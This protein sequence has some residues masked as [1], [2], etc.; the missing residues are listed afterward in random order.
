MKTV[1]DKLNKFGKYVCITAMQSGQMILSA[2]HTSVS[3]K[4]Y[5]N[6]LR[7]RYIG[8]MDPI[9]DVN[10]QVISK[11]NLKK[12]STIIGLPYLSVDYATLC[13]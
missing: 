9:T 13:T 8:S 5:Y 3:V 12:L 10:N 11:L 1:L 6:G 4:T 7:S 2:N